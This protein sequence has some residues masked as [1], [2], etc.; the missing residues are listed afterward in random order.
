[1][2]V[3]RSSRQRWGYSVDR[4]GRGTENIVVLLYINIVV[5][6]YRR[7]TAY[8]SWINGIGVDS[9]VSG[10]L[11]RKLVLSRSGGAL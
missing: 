10:T 7:R 2:V 1:V 9:Y 3:A 8:L 4:V 6:D 11:G 5:Y